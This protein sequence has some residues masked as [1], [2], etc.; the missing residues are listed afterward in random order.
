MSKGG[1]MASVEI[2]GTSFQY[3][4]QGDGEPVVLVHGSA[5]DCRTWDQQKNEFA[6]RFRTIVYS[7]RFHWPNEP[8]GKGV[9]YSM[10]QQVDDLGSLITLLQASPAHLVGHSYGAFLCLLLAIQQPGLVRSLVLAE[11]PVITLFVSNAPRP[12]EL[13][14]LLL[15]RPGIA[16][17][18][19]RFGATGINPAVKA[20]RRGDL[21]KGAEIFGDAIFGKGGYSRLSESKKAQVRDNLGNVSAEILGSGFL[22]LRDAEVRQIR[23]P[24]LLVTGANSVPLFRKLTDRL[25]QLLPNTGRVELANASHVMHEDNSGDFNSSCIEFLQST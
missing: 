7:R 25:E 19:V 22:P 5:S 16:A 12:S 14:G 3:L 6:R 2:D 23:F 4:E 24:T 15:R 21:E 18:I 1:I 20:F 13:L 8:I 9:D 10:Q 11:P 17:S